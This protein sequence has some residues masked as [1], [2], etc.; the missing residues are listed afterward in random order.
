MLP[1][2][3]TR[4]RIFGVHL[5]SMPHMDYRGILTHNDLARQALLQRALEICAEKKASLNLRYLH[6]RQLGF[7]LIETGH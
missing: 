4:S 7:R 6:E 2:V 5:T 3:L 1:L